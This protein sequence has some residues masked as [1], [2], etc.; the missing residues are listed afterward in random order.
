MRTINQAVAPPS[1]LDT[2]TQIN[3]QDFL[4]AFGLENLPWGRGALQGLCWLPARRFAGQIAAYDRGVGEV[5]LGPASRQFLS[6][7]V[8]C[9]EVEG[10][11]N[12]PASGPL[13]LL[14][15]HP[16]LTDAL[17]L[18]AS[19]PRSDLRVVGAER[20]FLQALPNIARHLIYVPEDPAQRMG[21]VRQVVN[22]LRRGQAVLT[23]PAG[24][25]EPDPAAM[26]G[27]VES[28]RG[29]SESIAIFTRLVP[30]AQVVVAI[31]SGV[32]WPAALH[33][34]LARLRRRP[35][36]REL[37]AAALQA[38]VQTL[39][40]FYQP[41]ATRVTYSPAF[42]PAELAGSGEAPA[43][44]QVITDHARR[45]IEGIQNRDDKTRPMASLTRLL[46][47]FQEE[48]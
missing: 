16:G 18:F 21:V 1:Q 34:P 22:C 46:S 27:A 24:Q 41:V 13:L 7:Y 8:R 43:V 23:F 11:E 31:V 19:I 26:P 2:L 47:P 9:L 35:A 3:I 28:L 25:I 5:G 20:P 30:Q 45:L 10:Q 14:S 33:S 17:A 15:N 36:D 6:A 39:L 48:S 4:V 32:F 42:R 12:I 38:L 44:N 29:W 37:M 40:P